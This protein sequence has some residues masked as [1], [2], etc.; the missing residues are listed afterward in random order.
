MAAAI[1]PVGKAS[2]GADPLI[3][4]EPPVD[5]DL[6][7]SPGDILGVPVTPEQHPQA[8]YKHQD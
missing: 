1:D 5:V 2:E 7:P 4:E 6:I 8:P 3:F